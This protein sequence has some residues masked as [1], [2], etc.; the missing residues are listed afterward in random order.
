M[1]SVNQNRIVLFSSKRQF[2]LLDI[3][4]DVFKF[5]INKVFWLFNQASIGEF[6]MEAALMLAREPW[7]QIVHGRQYLFWGQDLNVK[8]RD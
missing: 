1:D 5:Q 3:V 2:R 7:Q 6:P 8:M 4:R